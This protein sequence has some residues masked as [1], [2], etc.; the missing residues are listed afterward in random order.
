MSLLASLAFVLAAI[1][2]AAAL[3]LTFARYRNV[4]LHNIAALRDCNVVRDFRVQLSTVAARPAPRTEVRRVTARQGAP[5]RISF[6][7]GVRAA[8]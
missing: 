3:R 7:T 1:V 6:A 4:A 8:A 5:R 2:V